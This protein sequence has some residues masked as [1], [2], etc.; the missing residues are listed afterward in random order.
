[1]GLIFTLTACSGVKQEE[2]DK[3][4]KELA[5]TQEEF[6]TSE[7]DLASTKKD[8]ES[9]QEELK[10]NQEKLKTKTDEYDSLKKKHDKY[11]KKMKPFEEMEAAE[12][13]ARKVAAEQEKAAA[14][15][16]ESDKKAAEE[17]AAIQAAAEAEAAQAAE[18]AKGYE[19]GISFDQLSRTPDDFKGQKVKFTGHVVQVMEGS[20]K[21]E[22]RVATSGKYDNVIYCTYNSS[23]TPS[24]VLENDTITLYGVS[25][26]LLSYESTMGATITIPSIEVDQIDQ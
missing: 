14:E 22:L 3:V 25:K 11:T 20:Y 21:T 26:G 10:S 6:T 24:R 4:S 5:S 18:E 19:T 17:A 8:L 7:K 23:I 1:M 13:E 2:Y 9:T 15:Q 16:A 12:A